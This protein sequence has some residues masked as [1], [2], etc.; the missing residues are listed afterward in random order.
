MQQ[1]L[2]AYLTYAEPWT[3]FLLNAV[4]PFIHETMQVSGVD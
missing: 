3:E 2:A 4:Q 1:W